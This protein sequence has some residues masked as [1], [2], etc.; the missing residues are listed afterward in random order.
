[1]TTR[2][3][4]ATL[5]PTLALTRS[6]GFAPAIEAQGGEVVVDGAPLPVAWSSAEQAA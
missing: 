5:A 3:L 4:Q 2:L 6:K 1:M